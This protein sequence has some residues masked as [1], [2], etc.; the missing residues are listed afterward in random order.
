M[1]KNTI[2]LLT[3]FFLAGLMLVSCKD[4]EQSSS[5]N[6]TPSNPSS[7]EQSSSP[8]DSSSTVESTTPT[9]SSSTVESTT[10]TDPST[11]SVDPSSPSEDPS[12]EPSSPSEDPSVDPSSP[13]D[14]PSDDPSGE[15][16]PGEGE[17]LVVYNFNVSD[18]CSVQTYSE[19]ANFGKFT[20]VGG[21]EVRG[22]TKVW[23]NPDDSSESIEFNKSIKLGSSSAEMKVNVPGNGKLY[24]W[25]QN[26]SSSAVTQKIKVT[27]PEG[28]QE[29]E[30]AGTNESSPVVRLEID[31]TE[32]TYSIKRVSGTVDIFQAELKSIV[33]VAAESGFEIV[34]PG[35]VEYLEGDAFDAS[36]LNVDK[37]FGNGRT[38]DI[39]LNDPDLV[40]DSSNYKA[41]IPGTYSIS[42]QYKNYT[43]LTYDVVVYDITDF[44]LQFDAIEKLSTNTSYGNGVY[45]NHSVKEV[46][47]LNEAFDAKGLSYIVTGSNG[48]DQKDFKVTSNVSVTGFDSTTAGK[49][50]VTVTYTYGTNTISQTFNV[51]VVDT[52]PSKVEDTVCVKVDP[53]YNGTIGAVVEDYNMFTTIQQA[54][55][56]ID[57]NPNIAAADQKVIELAAGTY[58]E[59]LEIT[60]PNLT[61]KGYN[62][63]TTI[64]EW[65][66]LYGVDDAGGFTH[67]TD[68][69][70]TVAVRES[71]VNC[72]I[73]GVT[74]SNWYNSQARFTERG[75]DIER[76]L[77]LLV[78]ADQFVMSDGKLV[79]VQDTLELFTGRQ[80]FENVFISGY[81]D[82]IFGTNNTTY[83]TDCTIHSID[84]LKDDK[85]TA[86]YVTA[87]KGSNKGSGD[88]VTYGAIFDGCDFTADAGVTK[89]TTAIGR[90]WGSY[91]AVA[92]INSNLGDHISTAG[93]N[94]ASNKN[95]RYI[96]MNAKPTDSTVKYVEYNNTGD[97]AISEVVAGM[98]FL[99]DQEALNYSD[100]DV[101]FGTTNGA[102]GYTN[103]WDPTSN[104]VM[105]DNNIYYHFDGKSSITGTSYTYNQNINGNT[106]TFEG[107]AIDATTGKV[108]ARTS[109]TQINAGAKMSF[110]VEAN[111]TVVVN[112]YSG[113]HG[114]SLNGVETT[115]DTF[116]KHYSEATTVEFEALSQL[117]L[118]SIVVK[119][120][121]V[122]PLAATLDSLAISGQ[123]VTFEVG[124]E[125]TY[126][127]LVVK[128]SYSDSSL[129]AL[130]P[131][132]YEVTW[133]GDID[134]AGKYTVTVTSGSVNEQYEVTYVAAGVDPLVIV[135]NTTISF[136]S[137]GN[138]KTSQLI[139]SDNI[140]LRDNGGNNSQ[141][142]SG[143]YSIK[144]AAGASVTVNGY[145]SYTNYTVTIND[146]QASAAITETTHVIN[147]DEASTITF[148]PA[149]SNN[150]LY[151]IVV[152]YPA[153]S[154][155]KE[156]TSIT[157][158]SEG[159]YNDSL[160]NKGSANFRDNGTNNSQITGGSYSIQVKAGGVVTVNGYPSY[161]N[162]SV[163]INDG[164][165]SEAITDTTYV[166]TV[167]E[168]S[169]ITFTPTNNNN[170]FYS[171]D[172][173]FATDD[174]SFEGYTLDF[175]TLTTETGVEADQTAISEESNQIET[176]GL[177]DITGSLSARYNNGAI[178]ALE[179]GKKGIGA[180]TFVAPED[181]VLT[182][183]VAS[184]GSSNLSLIAVKVGESYIAANETAVEQVGTLSGGTLYLSAT[185][186]VYG[187][188]SS[189]TKTTITYTISKGD[190]VTILNPDSG[191]NTRLTALSIQLAE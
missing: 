174:S 144:V 27:G 15:L 42:V 65:D 87:F 89:G 130:N 111:T 186:N 99:T 145:P 40:I 1:K 53:N 177:V 182:I 95:T 176:L 19:D 190:V 91:A 161:T 131:S 77:A 39:E 8:K 78:Q 136:G 143:T 81:T 5:S 179:L 147:V 60:I 26:G 124:E 151:S 35:K 43:A 79:G 55:D 50:E 92:V 148:T 73:E 33:E 36:K 69:T 157:F 118:L 132:D 158:G 150:Y 103:A 133:N 170:Y 171:I 59:K 146:G 46:Y 61:L 152:A 7:Q 106:G 12:V 22:R 125:F 29:I 3:C 6:S 74:I 105:V 185:E 51:Y 180:L 129:I 96:A 41:N 135:E 94:D 168:D 28:E 126:A 102:V 48:D 109:D 107:I 100:F 154:Y 23:T 117:Y 155:I 191:R 2:K 108:T 25:V 187:V 121:Q 68:S 181:V 128:A 175:A 149:N 64:I 140:N 66:S 93:Y 30:F 11:P 18:S 172:V 88:Y 104:E 90:P 188:Y 32:G 14:D 54:L 82:F 101:I 20:I 160:L 97:G 56:Y 63:E 173:V 98:R 72:T 159:N 71:A 156:E 80:Y 67:T 189:G 83:F 9:E 166:I 183:S 13:S 86:G 141:I 52:A 169:T 116:A 4:P 162:Y 34:E 24:L 112:T 184:T 113:Y 37:L 138:Y 139:L 134:V 21:T 70:A 75:K 122:A 163:T 84:T 110:E 114:Y 57:G 178:Y 123:K 85:G 165:A 167:T 142:S 58:K 120:D 62:A 38:E 76:A 127:D 17:E 47:N 137:N 10:P 44:N 31:V 153:E 49:K 115:S 45:F 119:P 16:V 164:E